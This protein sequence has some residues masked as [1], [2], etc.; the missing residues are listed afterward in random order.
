MCNRFFETDSRYLNT[1]S[2]KDLGSI[3]S[4]IAFANENIL[5]IDYR[6][7]LKPSLPK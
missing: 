4:S 7:W 5:S 2:L 6:P 1:W 3:V